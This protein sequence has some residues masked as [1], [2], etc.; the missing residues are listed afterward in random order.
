MPRR[1]IM[2]IPRAQA[3]SRRPNSERYKHGFRPKFESNP[4]LARLI[5]WGPTDH[6]IEANPDWKTAKVL[7]SSRARSR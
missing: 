7:L 4:I 5:D 1:G 2:S 6:P 3:P